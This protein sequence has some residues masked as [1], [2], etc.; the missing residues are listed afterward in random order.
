MRTLHRMEL[1]RLLTDSSGPV[2]IAC[3][4][5]GTL[6]PIAPFPSMAR[7]PDSTEALL[8]ALAESGRATIAILSGRSLDHLR[9]R[10]RLP[11]ILAGNHGLEISGRGVEYMHPIA[12]ERTQLIGEA[13]E[14]IESRLGSYSGAWVENKGLTATIHFRQVDPNLRYKLV[15]DCR[16][17]LHSFGLNVGM[18]AGKCSLEIHPRVGWDK[19]RALSFIR[20]IAGLQDSRCM[21][22][23]D[24]STDESM[25]RA[26]PSEITVRVGRAA[27]TQARYFLSGTAAVSSTLEQTLEFLTARSSSLACAAG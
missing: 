20:D 13:R 5:D 18:R 26:L 23:G 6:A 8:R 4:F 19:G 3:D 15:W 14:R 21:I 2:L 17:E 9:D 24:D 10:V 1:R 12:A 7:L 11:C 16:Q 22:F 25:F 27:R